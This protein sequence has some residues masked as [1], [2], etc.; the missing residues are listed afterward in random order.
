M[1]LPDR[2]AL[3]WNR[4]RS[5]FVPARAP[6]EEIRRAYYGGAQDL[7]LFLWPLVQ[8]EWKNSAEVKA[9]LEE[10]EDY[11]KQRERYRS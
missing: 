3:T 7:F 11:L 10:L 6:V 9:L 4:Y 8:A 1:T 5:E 2:I